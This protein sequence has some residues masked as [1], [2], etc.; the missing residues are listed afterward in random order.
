MPSP[1][2]LYLIC[3]PIS[4]VTKVPASS[5]YPMQICDLSLYMTFIQSSTVCDCFSLA[6]CNLVFFCLDVNDGFHLAFLYANPISWHF[7]NDF[8][9]VA[10]LWSAFVL[11]N[12]MTEW[13]SSKTGDSIFFFLPCIVNVE[14]FHWSS[15]KY[16]NVHAIWPDIKTRIVGLTANNFTNVWK[17]FVFK[18]TLDHQGKNV[19]KMPEFEKERERGVR[20][21]AE[22]KWMCC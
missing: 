13:I 5:H 20:P 17:A 21:A 8:S 6:H 14:Y 18:H 3:S 11:Q 16:W 1:Q 19:V 4:S 2:C 15:L 10:Y 7:L 12:K 9:F 22:E